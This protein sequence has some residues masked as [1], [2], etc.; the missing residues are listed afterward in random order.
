MSD[1][2]PLQC[3]NEAGVLYA[4]DFDAAASL[5]IEKPFTY[6]TI[7]LNK[8]WLAKQKRPVVTTAL[9]GNAIIPNLP[10]ENADG[11]AV[12]LDKDFFGNQRDTANP[13]PGPFEIKQSGKQK[14]KVW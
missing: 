13:S 10:F 9:L 1:L 14:I 11:S 4:G 2:P 5:V 8:E 7:N 6:L 12:H 3:K